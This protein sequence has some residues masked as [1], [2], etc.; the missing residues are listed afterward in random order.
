MN[1]KTEIEEIEK[2]FDE[3][4]PIS[5]CD[6][7]DG[8]YSCPKTEGWFN[9]NYREMEKLPPSE[10]ECWCGAEKEHER[11]KAFFFKEALPSLLSKFAAEINPEPPKNG[12]NLKWN[13]EIHL[14]KNTLLAHHRSVAEKAEEIIKQ[15]P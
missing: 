13:G 2:R 14:D 4:F 3:K 7:D 9:D 11:L 1:F 5:H 15:L 8:F 10:R 6:V 12:R